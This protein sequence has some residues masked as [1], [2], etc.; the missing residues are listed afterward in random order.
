MF[1]KNKQ[2]SGVL[3]LESKSSLKSLC[4][5]LKSDLSPSLKLKVPISGFNNYY[6]TGAYKPRPH[7]C[8]P[9]SLLQSSA[10]HCSLL[11]LIILNVLRVKNAQNMKL[12]SP[13]S[14]TTHLPLEVDWMNGSL[15]NWNTNKQTHTYTQIPSFIREIRWSDVLLPNSGG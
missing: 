1:P 6:H 2:C 5:W 11:Y 10:Q 12:H 3:H 15:H 14:A 13:G 8:T 4:V 9:L 7:E